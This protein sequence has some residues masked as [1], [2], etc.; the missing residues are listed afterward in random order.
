MNGAIAEL[1]HGVK[2]FD[3]RVTN[4]E[5]HTMNI[6]GQRQVMTKHNG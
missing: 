2:G 4:V 3:Q 6:T 5:T 1:Q